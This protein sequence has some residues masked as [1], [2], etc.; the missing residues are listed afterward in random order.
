MLKMSGDITSDIFEDIFENIFGDIT[1]DISKD[2]TE[3]IF[4]VSSTTNQQQQVLG[5]PPQQIKY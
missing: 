3:D 5:F 4:R 1:K 2:I